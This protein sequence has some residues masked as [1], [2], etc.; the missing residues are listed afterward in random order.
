LKLKDILRFGRRRRRRTLD[1][2][3][4]Y[5][6]VIGPGTEFSGSL[7]GKDNYLVHGH[8]RGDC[9]LHGTLVIAPGG[10]WK[11]DVIAD[12]VIVGGELV[13]NVTARKKLELAPTARIRGDLASPS[14]AIAVGALYDGDVHMKQSR[15]TRYAERRG[16]GEGR[17]GGRAGK[18]RD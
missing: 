8:F 4:E 1:Q 2:V 18:S 10:R 14:I 3:K 7:H 13:G 11:G 5:T 9:D 6:T 12:N 16:T 15:I 17:G